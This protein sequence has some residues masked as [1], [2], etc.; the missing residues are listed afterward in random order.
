MKLIFFDID[1][2]LISEKDNS[3][4]ESTKNAISKARE[5]GHVC[6]VNTGR[7]NKLVKDWLPQLVTFDG[8]LCGCGTHIIYRNQT[9]M[10]KTFDAKT[11]RH[12]IDGLERYGIDAVLEG[13]ENNYHNQLEKM[14]TD[15][16]RNFVLRFADQGYGSYEEAIENFDKFYC[17]S[18][19]KEQMIGFQKE[20]SDL[21]DFIDRERGFY[22]I[23]PKGYSK[24][25][26]MEYI[27]AHLGIPMEETVAL[28]DSNNDLQMLQCAHTAIAMGNANQ[29]V[30]KLAKYVTTDVDEDGIYHALE[31]LKVL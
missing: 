16:F 17:Y 26:A 23:M 8:Y 6:I 20:Y 14:H 25:S 19:T 18:P 7:S 22:E 3:M 29:N 30:K 9:L 10:H 31:W 24:A 28:G 13:S 21:L 27:A 11:G 2:T 12:I 1:G 5:N 4:L 15:V